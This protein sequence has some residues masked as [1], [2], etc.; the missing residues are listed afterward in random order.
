[1]A[2]TLRNTRERDEGARPG[3]VAAVLLETV[4]SALTPTSSL[5]RVRRR[6]RRNNVARLALLR[7]L[8]HYNLTVRR[9][10]SKGSSSS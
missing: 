1:M 4:E 2:L 8:S 9:S 7:N 5:R 6:L 10:T 3:E